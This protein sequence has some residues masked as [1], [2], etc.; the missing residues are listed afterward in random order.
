[1]LF[2]SIEL[3]EKKQKIERNLAAVKEE[4]I[5]IKREDSRRAFAADVE[6]IKDY[7]F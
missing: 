6:R 4:L 7:R 5:R 1:M 3:R 2:I